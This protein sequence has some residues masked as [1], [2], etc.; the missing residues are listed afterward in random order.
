MTKIKCLS[1]EAIGKKRKIKISINEVEDFFFATDVEKLKFG[2]P[3]HY[4][5]YAKLVCSKLV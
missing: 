4:A 3:L 2:F 5:W 1:E